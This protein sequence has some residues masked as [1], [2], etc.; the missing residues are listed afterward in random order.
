MRLR[1]IFSSAAFSDS[2]LVW[3]TIP[4]FWSLSGSGLIL[5][6]AIWVA[7]AKSKIKHEN[8]DDLERSGYVAV[9]NEEQ[10]WKRNEEF[11][12]EEMDDDDEVEG[13]ASASTSSS[14]PATPTMMTGRPSGEQRKEEVPIDVGN[15]NHV[16]KLRE[17]E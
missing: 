13:S 11:E 4:D 2:R 5:G 17:E 3:G 6:S 15:Q 1:G 12:L 10:G 7:V 16:S 8:Q 9:N 14:T